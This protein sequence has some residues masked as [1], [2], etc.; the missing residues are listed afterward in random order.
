MKYEEMNFTKIRDNSRGYRAM[1]DGKGQPVGSGKEVDHDFFEDAIEVENR[2]ANVWDDLYSGD[3][4]LYRAA[5]GQLYKVCR[6]YDGAVVIWIR[7]GLLPDRA[8]RLRE[9]RRG[10]GSLRELEEKTGIPAQN[11]S[12]WENGV[13]DIENVSGKVLLR[14]ADALDVTIEELVG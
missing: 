5:D 4:P 3:T 14:L 1:Y 8:E 11:I 2:L 6:R 13:R 7:A 9:F 12:R 10:K